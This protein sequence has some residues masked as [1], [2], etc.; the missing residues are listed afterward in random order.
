MKPPGQDLQALIDEFIVDKVALA[1]FDDKVSPEPMSGCHLWTASTAQGYGRIYYRGK[2][3]SAHRI[4]LA[5]AQ[6][7]APG[8]LHVC[9]KCDNPVC[10]NPA[11]LWFGTNQ[12]NIKDRDSKGRHAQTRK[13]H[14]PAGH[15]YSAENTYTSPRGQRHCRECRRRFSRERS[16]KRQNDPTY[17]EYVRDYQRARYL[18]KKATQI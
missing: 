2:M 14:C 7:R 1:R 15:T 8:V 5:R 9:H 17:T 3:L 12:D 4:A 13:S 18:C 16:Q 6:G 11:H 10:V